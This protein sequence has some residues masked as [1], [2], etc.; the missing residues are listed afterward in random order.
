MV[1]RKYPTSLNG[2]PILYLG[3]GRNSKLQQSWRS[4]TIRHGVIP[5]KIT[6]RVRIEKIPMILSS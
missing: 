4:S 5:M 3:S 6:I 1:K 2:F